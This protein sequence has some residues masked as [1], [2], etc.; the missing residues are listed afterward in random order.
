MIVISINP[1]R[2]WVLGYI[3]LTTIEIAGVRMHSTQTIFSVSKEEH[4]RFEV[5]TAV[6]TK[7]TIFWDIMPCN[8]LK[9]KQ[10]HIISHWFLSWFILRPW[11]W[12]R[13]VPPKRRLTF[14]RLHGVISQKVV[15]FEEGLTVNTETIFIKEDTWYVS[16]LQIKTML[17]F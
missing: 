17:A 9:V 6:I 14:N 13:Y 16:H 7:S 2:S 1:L 4:I 10:N 15:P 12:R 11:R 3:C 5:L 8:P